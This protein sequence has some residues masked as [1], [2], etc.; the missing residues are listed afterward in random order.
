M[1]NS[2]EQLYCFVDKSGSCFED[3]S[4]VKDS[5]D[6]HR[7]IAHLFRNNQKF[8]VGDMLCFRDDLTEANF[9]WGRDFYIIKV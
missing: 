4:K 7:R 5:T 1:A 9:V 2:D 3:F 6:Y 8:S